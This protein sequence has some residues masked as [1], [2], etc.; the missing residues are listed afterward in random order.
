MSYTLVKSYPTLYSKNSRGKFNVWN[1]SVKT[2]NVIS[3]IYTLTKQEGGKETEFVKKITKG[4]N[5]GK[6]NETTHIEQA[7]SEALSKW[8]LK[9]DKNGY[10]ENKSDLDSAKKL[11]PMCAQYF[12]NRSKHIDYNNAYVQ[13]KLD[14]VRCVLTK[15]NNDIKMFSKN[16]LE[17]FNLDHIKNDVIKLSKYIPN[18][19]VLDGELYTENF[20]FNKINGYVRRKKD[21]DNLKE[22]DIQKILSIQ[23]HIFDCF[24]LEYNEWTFDERYQYLQQLFKKY[25]KKI[26]NNNATLQLVFTQKI[27]NE[28]DVFS[29][30][31]TFISQGFE[32]IMIRNGNGFYKNSKTRSNDLQKYKLFKDEE[33]KIVDVSEGMGKDEGTAIFTCEAKG[34]LF[35]VR[36][37]GTLEE[38]QEYFENKN[39]YI[40]KMLTVRFQ[41]YSE[42]DIPRFPVGLRVREID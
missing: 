28:D 21:S 23:F 1:I 18:N 40:G 38:R 33:F 7:C 15:N 34:G 25:R 41:E 26:K 27:N 36:P 24:D 11:M 12:D 5:I 37:K 9:K 6:K 20:P 22:E 30:N 32:G 19:I 16:G 10:R 42:E 8:N 29:V 3:Y 4:K 31:G 17:F 39:Y 13:P 14:G 2:D 35:N